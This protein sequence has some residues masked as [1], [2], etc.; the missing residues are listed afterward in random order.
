[1]EKK[2][3]LFAVSG[4][5][6]SGKT[7]L[8]T[9]LIPLL[10]K[11]GLKVA[12]IKHD[13]HDFEADVRG[14]D[15]YAHARAGAYG[16]AVFSAEKFM[17]VKQTADIDER[18]LAG[19][20]PE[21]DLILLE[22][23]KNSEY[24]KIEIVRNGNST[25]SVCPK[26]HLLAVASDFLPENC[27]G[28]PVLDL[29]GTQAIADLIAAYWY[30][31][32]KLSFLVL[33]GGLSS[34][35]GTDKSDLTYHGKTFLQI[36]LDKERRL[37]AEEIFVSGY[38][39]SQC[40]VPVIPDRYDKKGPLGG[41]EA[42]FRRMSRRDCLVLSVDVPLV[43][44]EELWGLIMQH[45]HGGSRITVLEHGEKQEPLIGIYDVSLADAMEQEI[46]QEKGSVFAF[47]RKTGYDVYRTKASDK[48]F[49][50]INDVGTY[51]ELE[52]GD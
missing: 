46:L 19:L 24:P 20:F 5:K 1:M 7:T 32:T 48:Y 38:R 40:D 2:P 31:R 28:I 30:A 52:A 22:G 18:Q 14:T 9:A 39:G 21:A 16:T 23:F 26:E 25:E 35:M 8:I 43:P 44:I 3:V 17:V 37:G 51:Q 27:T 47:L 6:N 15:S 45:M 50:N 29:G 10:I 36:Q 13:G 4:V 49:R 11:K 33:A 42:S 34:R 12:T 41:L